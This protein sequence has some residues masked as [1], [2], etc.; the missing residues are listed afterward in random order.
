M[1]QAATEI[2]NSQAQNQNPQ[3]Q[4]QQPVIVQPGDRVRYY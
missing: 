4:A 1:S 2:S 3:A